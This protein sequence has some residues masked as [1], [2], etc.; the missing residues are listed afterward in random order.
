MSKITSL[1]VIKGIIVMIVERRFKKDMKF[2]KIISVIAGAVMLSSTI[3]FAAAASFPEPFVS[4]GTA[5]GAVVYG[6]NAA[7][8]DVTA[9][10]DVQ[11][12]LQALVT[13][14]SGTDSSVSGTAWQVQTSS[15]KLEI[16]ESLQ[17]IRS[18]IGST[19]L[20]LL[21]NG[22][23]SNEKGTAKYEQYFYF[24]NQLSSMVNYTEDDD[25]N[26]GL[27]FM[28]SSGDVIARYVMSFT[29]SL[30]SDVIASSVLEDIEDEEITFLGKTYVITKAVNSS[31]TETDL[32]LMSGASKGTVSNDAE[33][34]LDG[35]TI[36]VVV[37]ATN[38]AQFTIDGETTTKLAEGD[39]YKLSD[40]T[41]LGVSDITYQDFSGG[42][43]QTTIYVGADKIFLDDGSAMQVNAETIDKAIVSVTESYSGG[44]VSITE[45]SINMTAE[46]D[47][48]VPVN[49]KL[50]E[51][52]DLDEPEVLIT[53]NWDIEF[54]GLETHN[55]EELKLA[56]TGSDKK[57]ELTFNNYDGTTITLPLFYS[58]AS[59]IFGGKQLGKELVLSPN[60]T[61]GI[62]ISK[63]D[64]FILNTADPKTAS[65]DARSYVIQ[66]KG[67]T[68]SDASTPLVTFD[69]LGVENGRTMTLSSTGT[70]SLKSL[71]GVDF[72]FANASADSTDSDDFDIILVGADYS[73]SINSTSDSLTAFLRTQYNAL[74]NITDLN[75]SISNTIPSVLADTSN[76]IVSLRADD[77]NR[78]GDDITLGTS[79]PYAFVVTFSN[80]TAAA[81]DVVAS[82]SIDGSE[83]TDNVNTDLTKIQTK[84]GIYIE[85]EDP[86]GSPLT[87]TATIPESIVEPLVYISSGDITVT[88]GSAGGGGQV[89]VVKDSEVSSVSTKNL[90]V[91]GGSCIN[92]VAA[93]ILGSDTPMCEA[94]FTTATG[95]GAGQYIIKTV[96]S[97][98][99]ATKTAMLV[100]GYNAADTT[101]AVAK[102]IEGV[103]STIDTEQVYPIVAA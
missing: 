48:Y 77:A 95:A 67:A 82:V 85:S 60:G 96:A 34:V 31:A 72:N 81:P 56:P 65:H 101:N 92:T 47:L 83:L 8:T 57:Y 70:F 37:S 55:T 86:S 13:T 62:N 88:P 36:S 3:A 75:A 84:Y 49:G 15:D 2:K 24:E 69:I 97:P 23:I 89:L 79:S 71:G 43:M 9:A 58:N 61:N 16:G 18:N 32:T 5:D 38:A 45:I 90:V 39:T 28:I 93:K 74:V 78:D 35:R 76:W 40:G 33:I 26:I 102:A 30:K 42:L 6:A 99:D 46:D 59:G 103:D 21:G 41:Y 63:N 91:V 20:A 17:D 29:S 80:G 54:K 87:L 94:A 19:E 27:F 73:Y 100:A 66:Y 1:Y 4:S 22:E 64:Y 98:Y 68:E 50:S 11:S 12:N 52:A 53:Q 7:I 14:S 10:I 44:D 25:E 51:A